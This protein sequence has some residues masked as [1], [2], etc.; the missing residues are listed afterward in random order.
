MHARAVAPGARGRGDLRE[1]AL[2]IDAR[3][4]LA[5]QGVRARVVSM[6]SHELFAAQPQAYR[7]SVLP[8]DVPRVSF[9][10]AHPMSWHRWVMPSGVALGLDRFGASAPYQRLYEELGLT[11]EAVV[12]AAVG[13]VG[14]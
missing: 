1:V 5:E 14:V 13:L 10:A 12:E 6:P 8:P 2:A 9:E 4:Q 11:A 7:D 3:K